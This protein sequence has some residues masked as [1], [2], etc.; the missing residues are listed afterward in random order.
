MSPIFRFYHI[1]PKLDARPAGMDGRP[2]ETNSRATALSNWYHP[3]RCDGFALAD[4][5]RY[6]D[7]YLGTYHTVSDARARDSVRYAT[8]IEALNVPGSI[9][10]I[11]R[12]GEIPYPRSV[13]A[14][15]S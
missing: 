10:K 11:G 14:P 12:K 15:F 13:L 8:A 6:P 7:C 1:D 2:Y 9:A 4:G 3:A 5:Y